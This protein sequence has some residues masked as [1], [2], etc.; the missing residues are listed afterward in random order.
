[1]CIKWPNDVYAGKLKLAGILCQSSAVPG[2]G[3]EVTCGVGINTL[4]REP[5]TCVAELA[6]AAAAA[7]GGAEEKGGVS[8]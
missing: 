2:A 8:R 4:N 3:F 6:A 5:T 7:G 1:M